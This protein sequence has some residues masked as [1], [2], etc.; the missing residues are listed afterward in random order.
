MGLVFLMPA[1]ATALDVVVTQT[2]RPYAL[3]L[4][5]IGIP[6]HT[7]WLDDPPLGLRVFEHDRA[8]IVAMAHDPRLDA[9]PSDFRLLSGPLGPSTVTAGWLRSARD[10]GAVPDQAPGT[11]DSGLENEL[12]IRLSLAQ[13]VAPLSSTAGEERCPAHD[14][15]IDL[16]LTRGDTIRLSSPANVSTFDSTGATSP[17]V[18]YSAPA[19]ESLTLEVIGPQLSVRIASG[20]TGFPLRACVQV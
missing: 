2:R 17:L 18:S 9:L 19:D 12:T 7:R 5:V 8:L 1:V 10:S 14:R 16:L 6:A 13:Q 3:A 20:V 15:P 4:L 11:V